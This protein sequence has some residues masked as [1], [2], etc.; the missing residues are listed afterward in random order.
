MKIF[1]YLEIKYKKKIY[2]LKINLYGSIQVKNLLMAILASKVC[3]LK[4]ENIFE[5]I[6]KYRKCGR[7][8]TIDKNFVQSIQKYS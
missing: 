7:Q 3:G 5:K 8:T 2:K 4:V 1:Q 6:D